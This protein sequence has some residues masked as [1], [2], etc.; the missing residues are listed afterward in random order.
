MRKASGCANHGQLKYFYFTGHH[1]KLG[2]VRRYERKEVSFVEIDLP[3]ILAEDVTLSLQDDRLTLFAR[4]DLRRIAYEWETYIFPTIT[5]SLI[6]HKDLLHRSGCNQF[7]GSQLPMRYET[8]CIGYILAE[9]GE[10]GRHVSR[11]NTVPR[12]W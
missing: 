1:V 3:G 6:V 8:F 4:N 7:T 2:R 10:W 12:D 9:L 5:V 11:T